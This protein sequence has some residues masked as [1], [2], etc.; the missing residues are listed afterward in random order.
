MVDL[1]GLVNL[2]QCRTLNGSVKE[3][4]RVINENGTYLLQAI[5]TFGI[6]YFLLAHTVN[7][8]SLFGCLQPLAVL[9]KF[10]HSFYITHFLFHFR[11][12]LWHRKFYVVIQWNVSNQLSLP[13]VLQNC[14]QDYK[15]SKTQ[16]HAC[17]G[18]QQQLGFVLP[19]AFIFFVPLFIKNHV[20]LP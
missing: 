19:F 15:S 3:T 9:L 8:S 16:T 13:Q 18:Q 14:T 6:V 5:Q 11:L 1:Q 17:R 12:P 2:N 20:H 7:I 4:L 10:N